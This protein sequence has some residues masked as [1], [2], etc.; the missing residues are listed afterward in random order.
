MTSET[1]L[2]RA[3]AARN[4]VNQFNEPIKNDSMETFQPFTINSVHLQNPYKSAQKF[5]GYRSL[6]HEA[7]KVRP[8]FL[9]KVVRGERLRNFL[10][11]RGF[12]RSQSLGEIPG[13]G[14]QK[15]SGGR[16]DYQKGDYFGKGNHVQACWRN[17]KHCE[18]TEQY[19]ANSSLHGLKYVGEKSL[20][21]VER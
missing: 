5:E 8:G 15:L 10:T 9:Q 4:D 13:R 1:Y 18:F 3:R 14:N 12:K 6:K 16:S 11:K 20:H 7:I 17:F 19:C 21:V 2:R